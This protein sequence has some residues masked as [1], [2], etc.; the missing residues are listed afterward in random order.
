MDLLKISQAVRKIRQQQNLTVEQLAKK[1]GFSKGF[2]SQVE[3]FRITPSLKAL[4]AIS[5]ALGVPL[6]AV[7]TSDPAIPDYTTGSVEQGEEIF[8]NNSGEYNMRY[9]AL[10]YQ[11][12]GRQL[13]PFIIEYRSGGRERPLMMH[14]TEEFY[15][16]LEGRMEFFIGND[17]KCEVLS[18]GQ[19]I[20]LRADLPHRAR[21]APGCDFARALVIYS[22]KK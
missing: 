21:L 18:A 4:N 20:Y 22:Q 6:S 10:A 9:L 14:D 2:I 8:R 17:E 15:L 3:N 7:L 5:S 1:S 12:L 11:Q 13:E 16:L 19:T